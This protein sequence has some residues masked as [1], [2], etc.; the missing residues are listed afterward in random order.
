MSMER[1][2]SGVLLIPFSTQVSC[3]DPVQAIHDGL[4]SVGRNVGLEGLLPDDKNLIDLRQAPRSLR[5]W[6]CP[7]C[8]YV[9]NYDLPSAKMGACNGCDAE[10]AVAEI[11]AREDA[12]REMA[13][14]EFLARVADKMDLMRFLF[15]DPE[16]KHSARMY[17]LA[18]A[19][20][21]EPPGVKK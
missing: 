15:A 2:V 20:G 11:F 13:T 17:R 6:D 18:E 5:E 1:M 21:W 7:N 12:E 14:G 9:R 8:G 3:N 10:V 19:F 4:R 16:G